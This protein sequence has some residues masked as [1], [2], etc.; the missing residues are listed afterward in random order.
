MALSIGPP[1]YSCPPGVA[2]ELSRSDNG[3]LSSSSTLRT[4]RRPAET[5]AV[6][7]LFREMI[8][9]DL[10]AE[11]F[12]SP[13]RGFFTPRKVNSSSQQADTPETQCSDSYEKRARYSVISSG[14]SVS[15]GEEIFK[16]SRLGRSKSL[17]GL[18]E[19][20]DIAKKL[21]FT[22]SSESPSKAVIGC[23]VKRVFPTLS[24]KSSPRSFFSKRQRV[25]S[26]PNLTRGKISD[27]FNTVEE[28]RPFPKAEA[29]ATVV[30]NNY[31]GT[32]AWEDLEEYERK[33]NPE[34]IAGRESAG[35]SDGFYIDAAEDLK[36]EA[37]NLF[38]LVVGELKGFETSSFED[39]QNILHS[40]VN[41]H[42]FESLCKCFEAVRVSD[43]LNSREA[44]ELK[45]LFALSV[46]KKMT[47]EEL[48]PLMSQGELLG[49]DPMD[50]AI[51]LRA[52]LEEMDV[53]QIANVTSGIGAKKQEQLFV[54]VGKLL[55]L[56]NQLIARMNQMVVLQNIVADL[57]DSNQL[58]STV[59]ARKFFHELNSLA[60]GEQFLMPAGWSGSE[61]MDFSGHAMLCAIKKDA[62]SGGF[63]ESIINTQ[64]ADPFHK[65]F[66]KK[67]KMKQEVISSCQ[68]PQE[69]MEERLAN[70]L[71]LSRS[72]HMVEYVGE[73]CMEISNKD[74][75]VS[76]EESSS[77]FN[78]IAFYIAYR[79]IYDE[80]HLKRLSRKEPSIAHILN[81]PQGTRVTCSLDV[82][83]ALTKSVGG[84]RQGKMLM[85]LF[86][87]WLMERSNYER[88]PYT[89]I[90][91]ERMDEITGIS[92]KAFSPRA[93][94]SPLLERFE[95]LSFKPLKEMWKDYISDK[96]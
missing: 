78:E 22:T 87:S 55:P 68:R 80:A 93:V 40:L 10:D 63:I 4:P 65:V 45:Q 66:L 81:T 53:E 5:G 28:S 41:S 92:A 2:P 26:C 33:F 16:D 14:K 83:R 3:L 35:S 64:Y 59:L 73:T 62:S 31:V 49:V 74:T 96:V 84:E 90:S 85:K 29:R 76:F 6:D 43:L 38:N 47:S 50:S 72:S 18:Y 8:A 71:L 42:G 60:E 24:E 52:F 69:G 17:S 89:N 32:F 7:S 54:L 1:A 61:I 13:Q 25:A 9:R 48:E 44:E 91:N 88:N 70:L 11:K 34:E 23:G 86:R 21:S 58:F 27:L 37:E 79:N 36:L 67:S 57:E 30:S 82:F 94:I 77:N 15:S 12:I 46:S 39:Q 95:F 75:G 51:A 20:G 56:L 19:L